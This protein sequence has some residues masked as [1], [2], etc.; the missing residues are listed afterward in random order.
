MTQT[1]PSTS[2]SETVA[3]RGYRPTDH[4]ACRMLWAEFTAESRRLYG[5][6]AHA[7]SAEE[8]DPGAGFEDY[9]T[10]LDLSGMW[11]AQDPDEG[12]IGFAGL[13]LEG[14]AGA[15]DPVAVTSAF[16]GKGVGGALLE[17][18]AQQ[19][20]RRGLRELTVSPSLRNVGAIHCLHR[21]GFDNVASVTLRLDLSGRRTPRTDTIDLHGVDFSY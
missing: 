1:V 11:V 16:R 3:I 19:A 5:A 4:H 6:G 21:T 14:R 2:R 10:R 13:I 7:S 17:H 20:R 12:V 15:I 18:V 8:D 9:L